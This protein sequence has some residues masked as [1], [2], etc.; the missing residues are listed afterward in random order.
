M[1]KTP[2]IA[3]PLYV[4]WRACVVRHQDWNHSALWSS[5]VPL[6]FLCLCGVQRIL[7]GHPCLFLSF[8][9]FGLCAGKGLPEAEVHGGTVCRS[10]EQG[11]R[12]RKTYFPSAATDWPCEFRQV[13][14]SLQPQVSS[15]VDGVRLDGVG[16]SLRGETRITWDAILKYSPRCLAQSTCSAGKW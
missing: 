13:T 11:F 3:S 8:C 6:A 12:V 5:E 1:K 16:T 4:G 2:I 9:A 15:L 10:W 14:L 7:P